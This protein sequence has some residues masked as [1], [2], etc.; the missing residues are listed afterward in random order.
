LQKVTISFVLYVR[1]FGWNKFGFHW[2]DINNIWHLNILRKSMEK[3]QVSFQIDKN[4]DYFTWTLYTFITIYH[5][6]FPRMGKDLGK[7]CRENQ[8]THFVLNKFSSR[9]LCRLWDNVQKYNT[10]G[11]VNDDNIIRRM[12]IACWVTKA[13]KTHS[14]Y[15]IPIA[16]LQQHCWRKFASVLRLYTYYI[17]CLG[18]TYIG[19]MTVLLCW[20]LYPPPPLPYFLT[21]VDEMRRR[22]SL[23]NAVKELRISCTSVQWKA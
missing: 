21:N 18:F 16:F 8:N 22:S 14:E 15:V 1:P 2:A 9:K 3:F 6:F 20:W 7:S 11:Q 19:A 23:R 13:T 12:R 5:S 17:A 4:N 10:A